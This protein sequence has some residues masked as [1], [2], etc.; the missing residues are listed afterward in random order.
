MTLDEAAQ[1]IGLGVVYTPRGGRI[2]D[3]IITSV[4]E[5]YVFVRYAGDTGS[6][7]TR[8]EDLELLGGTL[9]AETT[10]DF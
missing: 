8:P 10:D 5:H 6:K 9:S 4:N 2:E 7:A 3:G 1:A